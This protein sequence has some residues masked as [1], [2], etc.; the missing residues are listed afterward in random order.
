MVCHV[1]PEQE[2]QVKKKFLYLFLGSW[3]IYL[4][5]LAPGVYSIDGWSM[6]SVA[7]SIVTR[8]GITV[9]PGLGAVGRNGLIYSTWYPL[10]SI[11]AVPVVALAV[12]A[13]AVL[14]L[15]L[16]YVESLAALTLPALYTALTVPLVYFLAIALKSTEE[17]AWLAA[18]TYGFATIAMTYTRDFYADPLL[19]LL[20]ALGLTLA[21]VQSSPWKILSVSALAILAKPTGLVLGP[22]LSLY[23]YVKTR[24]FWPSVMPGLGTAVGMLLYFAYNFYRFGHIRSFGAGWAFSLRFVPEGLTGLLISPGGGLLWFCTCVILS[25][26]ALT[27]VKAREHEAWAVVALA[28]SFLLLHSL[29]IAWSGGSSWGPRLLLPVLPGLVALTGMLKWGGRNLLITAAV[30]GFL[31]NAPTLFSSYKRY[32]SEAGEQGLTLSNLMWEPSR[33]PLIH[34]WPAAYRQVQDARH[35][36]VRDLL[37]QRGELPATKIADSRALRIVAVW[38]WLLPIVHVSRVWGVLASM[39]LVAIG[40]R[41][42]IL[43]RHPLLSRAAVELTPGD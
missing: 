36:D 9:P 39:V 5:F 27:R 30:V 35:V 40:I 37:A 34:A 19:A 12:Q 25:L 3:A 31:I 2:F 32:I 26:L 14:H 7:D 28:A 1:D 8:H 20:M 29:W 33:S 10:Q 18:L 41:L 16:H 42:I 43:A 11:L 17:G 4:A 38:W 24:R 6:L 15:P 13:S 22:I 23:L 21:F